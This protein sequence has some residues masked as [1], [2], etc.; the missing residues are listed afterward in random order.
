MEFDGI[1]PSSANNRSSTCFIQVLGH[2][3][4]RMPHTN[5]CHDEAVPL[6]APS[7]TVGADD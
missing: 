2:G 1:H 7:C 3:M 4:K 6:I 5:T